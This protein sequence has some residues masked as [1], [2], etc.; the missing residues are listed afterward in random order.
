MQIQIQIENEIIS[1]LKISLSMVLSKSRQTARVKTKTKWILQYQYSYAS[2]K[3]SKNSFRK[4]S[5]TLLKII[6]AYFLRNLQIS[7][8]ESLIFKNKRTTSFQR[9]TSSMYRKK[10]ASLVLK[11][12]KTSMKMKSRKDPTLSINFQKT[13]VNLI[14]IQYHKLEGNSALGLI[15][16]NQTKNTSKS[17]KQSVSIQ[18]TLNSACSSI[19]STQQTKS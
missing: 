16:R 12:K 11:S 19:L 6:F 5:F 10:K 1:L 17:I 2:Q 7:V 8:S 15:L 14:I 18:V 9:Q 13:G 3:P 4:Q